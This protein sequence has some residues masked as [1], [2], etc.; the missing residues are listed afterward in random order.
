[1]A[2]KTIAK[3][4]MPSLPLVETQLMKGSP[5]SA[6]KRPSILP[7]LSWTLI[8]DGHTWMQR[9]R[10]FLCSHETPSQDPV[11]WPKEKQQQKWFGLN[12]G[13]DYP[14]WW[15]TK[16][17]KSIFLVSSCCLL[18]API[19]YLGGVKRVARSKQYFLFCYLS[20]TE[21]KNLKLVE[22]PASQG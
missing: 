14:A 9:R 16:I 1:M 18:P 19:S 4:W 12:N 11:S 15:Y 8:T 17:I 6:T 2:T 10:I 3:P 5:C 7:S 13:L 22:S 20:S 21:Y